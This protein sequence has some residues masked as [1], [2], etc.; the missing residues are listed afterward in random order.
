MTS[1]FNPPNLL[2]RS[3]IGAVG[4]GV[5]LL[6]LPQS[7]KAVSVFA[8]TDYVITPEAGAEINLPV[9]GLVKFEGLPINTGVSGQADTII[10]RTENVPETGG[11][12]PLEIVG[13]SLRKLNVGN[14]DLFAGLQSYRGGTASTGSMTISHENL[15]TDAT[16]GTWDSSFTI[17][18]TVVVVPTGTLESNGQVD[19]VEGLVAG[20][21]TLGYYQCVDF[22]KGPFSAFDEPWT[23]EP[24]IGQITGPNLVGT[25]PTNFYLTGAVDHVSPD[26]GIHRVQPQPVPWETD[27]L[28]VIGSTVLFGFGLWAKSKSAK[29]NKNIDLD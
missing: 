4:L 5:A 7:A 16:Q 24:L 23:H 8:G 9:F 17:N 11:T 12:T 25:D 6:G 3:L 21:G 29:S 22:T 20:C 26:G 10:N 15:D 13:L 1:F 28:S 19:F 14:F 2:S 27:A 18:G